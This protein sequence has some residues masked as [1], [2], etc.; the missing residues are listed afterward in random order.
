MREK[1]LQET[2]E[3]QRQCEEI[4]MLK[5]ERQRQCEEIEMLKRE[6]QRQCEEIERL[7]G[8]I[9]EIEML[10]G[11][12]QRQWDE[13]DVLKGEKQR[14]L[15]E[16]VSSLIKTSDHI[17]K[18]VVPL[19]GSPDPSVEVKML[20]GKLWKKK[21]K[22]KWPR[23]GRE[24]GKFSLKLW[25]KKKKWPSL[26]PRMLTEREKKRGV[27]KEKSKLFLWKRKKR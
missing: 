10:K 15:V 2:K 27:V 18:L 3:R 8:L 16:R 4:E 19:P 25:K 11:E 9:E 24:Q 23:S 6:R 14:Q 17:R 7:K 22:K 26:S 5:G 20:K 1:D 13:K 12:Q 21:R